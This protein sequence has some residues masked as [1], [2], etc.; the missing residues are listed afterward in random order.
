[1]RRISAVGSLCLVVVHGTVAG[2]AAQNSIRAGTVEARAGDSVV[3]SITAETNQPLNLL[4]FDLSFDVA[5]C[6]VIENA[7][8]AR[9]GRT[10]AAI[11]EG[12]ARCPEE[13]LERFVF[14]NLVGGAAVP[15]G[16]GPIAEW[17][18]DI[19]ADASPG[20]FPLAVTV[21]QAS[22]GPIR[23]QI[24]AFPGSIEIRESAVTTPT[25][26]AMPAS[27]PTPTVSRTCTVDCDGDQRVSIDELMLAVGVALGQRLLSECPAAD[28]DL[29]G[30]VTVAEL[31][32]GIGAALD[33]CPQ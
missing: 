32:R 9:A 20:V 30:T 23:V 15:A 8:A 14:L 21:N 11:Q 5:L 7:V 1:M 2:S 33:G 17:R 29:D 24:D 10:N 3:V 16:S 22:N 13:G 31:V 6:D 18:F 12:G 26:T 28:P 19:R 4:S 27:T 25:A